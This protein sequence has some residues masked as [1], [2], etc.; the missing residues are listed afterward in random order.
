MSFRLL[1]DAPF[2]ED[3]TSQY[4]AWGPITELRKAIPDLELH[5]F[6]TVASH[7]SGTRLA[8]PEIMN[9]D[10]VM[11]QRPFAPD[12]VMMAHMAKIYKKPLWVDYDD[13]LLAVPECNPTHA[14]YET[15]DVK[16]NI[17]SICK[18]ADIVTVSTKAL[19]AKLSKFNP[20]ILVVPNG[21]NMRL[22][23]RM[24]PA[25]PRNKCVMWRGS[26]CHF[27]DLFDHTP[28]IL[29]AYKEFPDWSWC[30]VGYNPTLIT[31]QMDRQKR[32]R[33]LQFDN[34]YTNFIGNLQKLRAAVQ[35]VPL[36]PMDFNFCK[37]RIA[38][39]EASLAGS[40]VLAPDWEEWQE[41]TL[42]RYSGADDFQEKLFSMLRTPLEDLAKTNNKDWEWV[43][44]HRVLTA[45]NELRKGIIQ[46]FRLMV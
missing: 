10:A 25:I 13:D 5:S 42:Y 24:D 3:G 39:V 18:M 40:A 32:V 33:Y 29:A 8:W 31:R 6:H 4:R 45:T 35:I 27:S 21:L 41:G 38:H 17:E 34:D 11:L 37:S 14:N 1:L 44:Q 26:H 7:A 22:L 19:G 30:F 2:P 12:R 23:S 16:R 9:V 43:S 28:Q 15:P 20:K 46:A 36:A